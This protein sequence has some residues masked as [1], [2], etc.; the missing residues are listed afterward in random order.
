MSISTKYLK[1]IVVLLILQFPE[2]N[3]LD[4]VWLQSNSGSR[5]C[6]KY[7]LT[8]TRKVRSDFLK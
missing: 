6:K 2:T 3:S 5:S 8:L 7:L 4:P 1:L